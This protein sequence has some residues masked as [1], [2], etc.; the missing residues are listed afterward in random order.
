M[1]CHSYFTEKLS[2][3]MEA[4]TDSDSLPCD[5]LVL[6]CGSVVLSH[7]AVFTAETLLFGRIDYIVIPQR[8]FSANFPA[9]KR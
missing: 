9:Q 5:I 7:V 3:R 2:S 6:F 1:S 4:G 8:E